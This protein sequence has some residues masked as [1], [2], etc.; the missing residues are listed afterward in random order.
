MGERVFFFFLV[1]HVS[2]C[3]KTCKSRAKGFWAGLQ[4]LAE[5]FEGL[6][7][8]SWQSRSHL[9]QKFFFTYY[10]YYYYYYLLLPL[11]LVLLLLPWRVVDALGS[12]W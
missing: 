12:L 1:S 10:C 9:G 6:D 8:S 7:S 5:C 4:R 11:L 2:V 3:S